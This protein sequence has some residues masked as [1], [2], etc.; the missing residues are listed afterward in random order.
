MTPEP[1][2]TASVPAT[3]GPCRVRPPAVAGTFYPRDPQTL[4]RVVADCVDAAPLPPDLHDAE[5][6]IAAHA[7][8]RYSGPTAAAAYRAAA[9]RRHELRRV[10]VAG[11]SHR[12]PVGGT[13]VGVST[14]DAWE[15]PLGPVALDTEAAARLV[16]DGLAVEAD[17][18]HA[19]EHSV[20]VQMP[21]VQE[22]LGDVPVLPLVV[23]RAA[24]EDVAAAFEAVWGGPE[25][26]LVASSDLS[27]YQ[28]DVTAR[29]HDVRT[30]TAI[31][32]GRAG[33]VGPQDACGCLAIQGLLLAATRRGLAP[34]LLGL[35]TSA[36]TSG[37]AERVVGYG[38]FAFAPPEPLADAERRWLVALA[39]RAIEYEL[40][41]GAPYPLDDAEVPER[42]R[43]PG[44]SFVTLERGR[45]LLGCIGSL[46]PRRALWHDVALNAR[47]A[48]FDDPRFA[49]LTAV[50]M[51]AAQVE[52]SVLSHLEEIPAGDPQAVEASVRPGVDG[53]VLEGAGRRGTFLPAVW[54]KLPDPDVF[55]DHLVQKA[56]LPAWPAGARAWRY[57]VDVA[58]DVGPASPAPAPVPGSSGSTAPA[59]PAATATER[60]QP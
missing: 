16:A 55:V 6:I 10:V 48:A 56:G 40:T 58:V 41:T 32:E 60:A 20:E 18:A 57:T 2:A 50:H 29:A 39:R 8:Y 12:L 37:D 31:L 13:G 54:A 28:D 17:A 34:R 46:E 5:A 23:G 27:H 26:L 35:T 14:A 36:P 7:G 52:V 9:A 59:D 24:A 15:T 25:T 19:P 53:V 42:V 22:L 38:A 21:F 47:A 1:G 49:P 43:V 4:R 45:E 3:G 51:A 44:A 33:D 11:P 30:A